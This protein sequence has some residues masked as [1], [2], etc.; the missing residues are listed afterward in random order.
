VAQNRLSWTKHP[1]THAF[2]DFFRVTAGLLPSKWVPN[3]AETPADSHAGY[4][5]F[6]PAKSQLYR[7]VVKSP[8]GMAANPAIVH[9][10][11]SPVNR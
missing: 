1:T 10:G 7:V 11:T 6:C 2:P 8:Q 5:G 9:L 3:A 4:F